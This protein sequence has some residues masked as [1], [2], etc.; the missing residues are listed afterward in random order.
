MQLNDDE[1]AMLDG[2][3]G[4]AVQRA[5]DL[6]VRYGEAL[7]ASRLVDTNN[8]CGTVGATMP[9]LRDYAARHG[10][11]D[12]VFSEFNLD[13][14]E[15]VE[16]PKAK[17][18]SSHLQQGLDPQHAQRQGI[19]GEIVKLYRQGEAFTGRL[20]IQ[21][22][23]TCAPYLTGNVP[24]RGE[25]CAWMESSAVIYINAVLGARSNAEGRESTGAAMLTGKIPYWGLHLDENRGGTHL[26]EL[27]VDVKTVQDWGL[28]GYYVG[29]CVQDRIPV[30]DGLR[31]VPNLPKL[32]H[33]GAAAASSGGVEMYHIVG[34]T[35]EARSRDEA[36]R[37]RKPLET[38]RYGAAERRI[39]Y[40]RVNTTA[41]DAQ[42]DFVMLGC[43]H[44]SI[45]QIWEVCQLLEGRRIGTNT[46]LWIFTARATR[47]LADQAGY[48]KLIE[49]A[50]GVLMTDTCSAI[51]RVM[52]KGTRVVALDSAK[53]AHYLP[54]IMGVQ[55]WFGTTADCIEAAVSGRWNGGLAA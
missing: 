53:Q 3:D 10:G 8:V 28:L 34:Q 38:I 26:I 55:A 14:P 23:N 30:I 13:S 44:Y 29:E 17:V 47:Q 33:F 15:V 7:G 16:V 49:D 2:R 22:L 45:E 20:G 51:G 42:V 36:F 37:G 48:T 4:A 18:F 9:F 46:E 43:P 19:D 5:M 54:A 25:H 32:K 52:P 24:V 11:L 1:R 31:D 35:P 41:K 27:D 50:G 12:A 21:P 39:A 40:E 6:L